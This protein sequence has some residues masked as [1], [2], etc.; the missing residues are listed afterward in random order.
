MILD[1]V[2][3]VEFYY[4]DQHET[5]PNDI[6]DHILVARMCLYDVGRGY[7]ELEET[8]LHPETIPANWL[9]DTIDL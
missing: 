2:N 6:E 4:I 7:V 8:V 3:D 9:T 1:Y 5:V